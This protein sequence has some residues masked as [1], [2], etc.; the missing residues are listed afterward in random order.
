MN[1]WVAKDVASEVH[2]FTFHPGVAALVWPQKSCKWCWK[3]QFQVRCDEWSNTTPT[4]IFKWGNG[5]FYPNFFY[6]GNLK[7]FWYENCLSLI[8]GE[9]TWQINTLQTQIFSC[10]QSIS[11]CHIGPIYFQFLWFTALLG[12]RSPCLSSKANSLFH[13]LF[14]ISLVTQPML[15]RR[16]NCTEL[17]SMD[18]YHQ[19]F[20]R[21]R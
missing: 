20:C 17:R 13:P 8:H 9:R 11:V 18:Y 10:G 16:P 14:Y 7:Y 21:F 15:Q 1:E 5:L 6:P 3:L 19:I 2:G 4:L 12:V